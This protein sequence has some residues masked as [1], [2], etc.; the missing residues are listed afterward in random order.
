MREMFRKLKNFGE[1]PLKSIITLLYYIGCLIVIYRAFLWG[2]A[3]YL[4][5]FYEKEISYLKD[6]QRWHTSETVN[7][8][9]LGVVGFIIYFIVISLAWKL[10][11]ELLYIIFERISRK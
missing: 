5:N 10:I 2:R 9:P 3:I 11:C 8:L 7:N 4:A 1:I 6:N